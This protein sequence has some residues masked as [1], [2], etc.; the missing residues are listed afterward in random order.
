MGL[1]RG[2]RGLAFSYIVFGRVGVPTNP[3]R[4]GGRV[5]LGCAWVWRG[6]VEGVEGRAVDSL[7]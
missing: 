4:R 7:D 6:A 3:G 1:G 2:A 5:R